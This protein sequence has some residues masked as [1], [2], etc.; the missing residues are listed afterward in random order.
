[1]SPEAFEKP[2]GFQDVTPTLARKKREV[3]ARLSHVFSSWGY[4]EVMTPMLEYAETVGKAS[5]IS[6]DK[7]FRLIGQEKAMLV[8]RPDQ[9]AP[10]ARMVNSILQHEPLPLRL[11]YHASVFRTQ[12]QAAGRRAELYQTGVELVGEPGVKADAELLALAITALQACQTSKFR[13]V[14]GHVELLAGLLASV[15]SSQKKQTQ[16]TNYLIKRD[17]VGFEALL[18]QLENKEG[19][20][21]ILQLC[22][23]LDKKEYLEPLLSHSSTQVVKAAK[24]LIRIWDILADYGYAS[25][26]TVDIRLLG[27]IDYYT[28]MYLEGFADGVGFAILSGGRY[29]QL[30]GQ[31]GR[32]L[33]ATG[34]AFRM[35]NLL[36]TCNIDMMETKQTT[37]FYP[38]PLRKT[39]IAKAKELRDAGYIVVLQIDDEQTDLVWRET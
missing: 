15:C 33:P 1:M 21:E 35:N 8:L 22:R 6:E 10:I 11:F 23:G 14:V 19:V 36:D 4:Q 18:H 34:F 7:M 26:I 28:G 5:A 24:Q 25:Y 32:S 20:A 16:L 30:Y 38:T 13:L 37:L 27:N 2:I 9:T 39:A 31:F 17:Y 29:D 3:E 12:E